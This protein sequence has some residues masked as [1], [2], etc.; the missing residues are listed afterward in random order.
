MTLNVM[1]NDP[2]NDYHFQYQLRVCQNACLVQ[3]WW[4]QLKFVTSYR[5]D[6]LAGRRADGHTALQYSFS[7]KGQGVIRHSWSWH[8]GI[9]CSLWLLLFHHGQDRHEHFNWYKKAVV[10][11]KGICKA[12][13]VQVYDYKW[14]KQIIGKSVLFMETLDNMTNLMDLT[15]ATGVIFL[16]KLDSNWW[17]FGMYDLAIWWMTLKNSIATLLCYISLYVFQ[18]HRWV[19]TGFT[20]WKRP[21]RFKISHFTC[22]LEI[23]RMTLKNNIVPYVTKSRFIVSIP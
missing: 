10:L 6:N 9:L 8:T 17:F 20:V 16:I 22:D 15:I 19:Q 23:W 14:P 5:V 1:G 12:Y 21:I 4:F 13:I 2:V 11:Y 3:I 7:L 18:S